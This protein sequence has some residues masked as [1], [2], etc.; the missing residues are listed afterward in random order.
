[1]DPEAFVDPP[2]IILVSTER[3]K[4]SF[5]GFLPALNGAVG[6][7]QSL[8]KEAEDQSHMNWRSM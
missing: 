2:S 5:A 6:T 3:Q 4:W 1:L 8:I 7:K